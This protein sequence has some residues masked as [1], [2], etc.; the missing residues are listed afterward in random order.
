MTTFSQHMHSAQNIGS[1]E[2]YNVNIGLKIATLKHSNFRVMNV[3]R[4]PKVTLIVSVSVVE[5]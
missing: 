3:N 1:I 4:I 2:A 5:L